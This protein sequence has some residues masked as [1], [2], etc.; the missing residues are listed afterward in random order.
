MQ[1]YFGNIQLEGANMMK[2]TVK[3]FANLRINNEKS[4]LMDF[5]EGTTP[6][7]IIERLNIPLKDVSIIMINGRR[8][9]LD[10]IISENDTVAI[11]PPVG[12]G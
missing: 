4:I 12:G 10:T 1:F 7:D 2:I 9:E 3:L 11:F 6:K 5:P 8:K